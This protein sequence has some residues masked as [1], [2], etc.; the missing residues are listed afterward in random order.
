MKTPTLCL[1]LLLISGCTHTTPY[2]VF[3]HSSSVTDG[4]A[5]V[6]P[7]SSGDPETE[8][9]AIGLGLR[10]ERE[11]LRVSGELLDQIDGYSELEGDDP[12]FQMRVE[13]D[14]LD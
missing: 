9:N 6:I 13:Y 1:A 10:Y 4:S 14:L 3:M 11:R 5:S 8:V 12:H 7:W 2:A